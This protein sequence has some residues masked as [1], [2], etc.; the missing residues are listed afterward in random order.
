MSP[1]EFLEQASQSPSQLCGQEQP[2]VSGFRLAAGEGVHSTQCSP[3]PGPAL[4]RPCCLLP[5]G[6]LCSITCPCKPPSVSGKRRA[7]LNDNWDPNL[8]L[9]YLSFRSSSCDFPGL[10]SWHNIFF[11]TSGTKK[12]YGSTL[13]QRIQFSTM[14]MWTYIYPWSCATAMFQS[15]DGQWSWKTPGAASAVTAQLLPCSWRC[16]WGQ[17]AVPPGLSTPWRFS[18]PVPIVK[19]RRTVFSF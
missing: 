3:S 15:A 2:E 12:V 9:S 10:G 13:Q 17:T 4:V 1:E 18:E 8:Y 14:Y 7:R 6:M 19:W 5:N 16:W 11:L